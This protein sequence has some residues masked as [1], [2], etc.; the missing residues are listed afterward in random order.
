MSDCGCDHDGAAA[1]ERRA[2]WLLVA[3]NGFMFL[4]EGVAGLWAQSTGLSADSLDMFADASVYAIALYA[5][6]RSKHIQ[7]RAAFACGL[8]QLLL[9]V[10]VGVDV[11]RRFIFGSEPMSLIM[12]T[13][14]V[15]ALVAN[16]SCLMLLAKHRKGGL[17]MRTSWI[18]SSNDVIA[19]LGVIG[20]GAL[21]S[22]LESRIP[23]LAIGTIISIIV[24]RGGFRILREA[25]ESMLD[26][27]SSDSI[28]CESKP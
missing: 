6:G 25:R 15:L 16:L 17:L 23:D 12:V 20:S 1:L 19:N 13:V 8:V 3:I 11:L 5:I 2:L 4:V 22:I 14:G 7:A 9:G 21:V 18:F 10:G 26:K 28:S 27:T 24:I